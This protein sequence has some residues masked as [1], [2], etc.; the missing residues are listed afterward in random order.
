MILVALKED[1]RHP[2]VPGSSFEDASLCF[3][4]GNEDMQ[5]RGCRQICQSCHVSPSV[6][7]EASNRF[8][9]GGIGSRNKQPQLRPAELIK[10]SIG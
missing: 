5:S 9:R 3:E 1:A 8:G 7:Q 10:A 6:A 4:G 2:N